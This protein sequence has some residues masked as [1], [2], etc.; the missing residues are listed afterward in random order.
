MGSHK[1]QCKR[2]SKIVAVTRAGHLRE[3]S[4]GELRLYNKKVVFFSNVSTCILSSLPY[5]TRFLKISTALI[6][7]SPPKF[8]LMA[9]SSSFQFGFLSFWAAMLYTI[10]TRLQDEK[11][12]NLIQKS[13]MLMV[14]TKLL[15][16]CFFLIHLFFIS[17]I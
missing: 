7:S 17:L 15:Q 3:W 11:T 12:Q 1:Q 6:S 2:G 16:R 14:I 5:V 13:D 8:L 10:F 4:Q 9:S